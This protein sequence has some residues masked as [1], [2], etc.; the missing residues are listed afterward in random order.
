M[1]PTPANSAASCQSGLCGLQCL[2]GY[3]D[4]NKVAADGCEIDVAKDVKNCGACGFACTFANAAASCAGGVCAIAACNAGWANCDG[5]IANGCEAQVNTNAQHCGACGN[6]CPGA[7]NAV[8]VCQAGTCALQCSSGFADCDANPANGC[9]HTKPSYPEAVLADNPV[10]YWRLGEATGTSIADSSGNGLDLTLHAAVTFGAPGALYCDPNKAMKFVNTAEGWLGR[11]TTAALQP[12]AALSFEF[13]MSL[14]GVP[15]EYEKP[16]WYGDAGLY[17]WGS[18]GMQRDGTASSDFVFM[19]NLGGTSSWLTTKL[20]TKKDV[21]YHVVATYDGAYQRVYV[22]GVSAT[23][24]SVSG[25]ISYSANQGQ[26]LAIGACDLPHNYFNGSLDEVAFYDKALS[27]T[28]VAA[29]W[30]AA[31]P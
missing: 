17:P 28:R 21:W 18:W 31:Q 16:I 4:C 3:A 1:C 9:E 19:L 7:A 8:G 14:S 24:K 30:A 22:D 20:F 11:G 2:S 12:T 29:H 6:A 23:E 5:N 25:A 27:S 13:W 26:A 15:V 10:A